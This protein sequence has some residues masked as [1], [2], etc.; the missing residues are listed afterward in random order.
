MRMTIGFILLVIASFLFVKASA[1]TISV[2]YFGN[3][4]LA[5][6]TCQSVTQ[7][8][9]IHRVCYDAGEGALIIELRDRYYGYCAIEKSTVQALLAADS[10]GTFYNERIK[11]RASGRSL[12]CIA[13]NS[14]AL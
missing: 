11:G 10:M 12:A 4:D 14:P 8:S 1:E 13:H 5:G 6:F 7:S 3:L 2:R 9:F